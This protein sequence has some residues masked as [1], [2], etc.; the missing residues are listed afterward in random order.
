M[1]RVLGTACGLA[2]EGSGWVA[3]EGLV[4]TNAH[5][6]AGESDTVVEV[7]GEPP[8]LPAQVVAFD[9]E[10]DIALLRVPEL[11]RPPC[12]SSRTAGSGTPR[13]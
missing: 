1:V 12:S 5:V 4:V 7:D 13:A 9:K 10:D 8:E 3:R 2:I 6:V 11:H